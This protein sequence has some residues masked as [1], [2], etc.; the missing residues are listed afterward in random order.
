MTQTDDLA[1]GRLSVRLRLCLAA[2]ATCLLAPLTTAACLR[3]NPAGLGTHQQ[4]GLPPC[5]FVYLFE[6]RCPSCGMTTSWSHA[7]RGHWLQA[8]GTNAGGAA[9]AAIALLAAPWLGVSAVCG[10]WWIGAP[11]DWGLACGAL[12]VVAVTL[13]DWIYRLYSG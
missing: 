5:T 3:P 1:S 6:T 2:A 8:C 9:L 11:S 10:R 4:L 7:V 13:I 12:C